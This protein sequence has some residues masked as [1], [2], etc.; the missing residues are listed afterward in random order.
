MRRGG[1]IAGIRR[2]R[3]IDD[4]TAY[5][6]ESGRCCA[7]VFARS[8]FASC[9]SGKLLPLPHGAMRDAFGTIDPRI[10]DQNFLRLFQDSGCYLTDLCPKPVDHLDSG[11][12]QRARVAGEPLLPEELHSASTGEDCASATCDC[13][14]RREG[15]FWANW[16]GEII[17]LLHP[18]RWH[19]HRAE[20]LQALQPRLLEPFR[21]GRI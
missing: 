21:C 19:H 17:Q 11:S 15:S 8:G 2:L 4:E 3:S 12:R 16:R 14:S 1:R 9:L 13:A 5:V 6:A 20:F 7:R 18:G 10:D